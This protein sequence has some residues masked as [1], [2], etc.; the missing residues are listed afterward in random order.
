MIQ[1]TPQN[2]RIG[3]SAAN[4]NEAIRAAGQV[5]V[6]SG[7]IEPGYIESMI[8]REGQANTYLGNGISIPHGMAKDRELI[9]ATGISVVQLPEGV[10]WGPGKVAH[11]IV[12]IAAKSDEHLGV[13]A[14]LT[15]V[16][17]DPAKAELLAKTK[18]A[19]DIIAGLS[20]EAAEAAGE[21]SEGVAPP[22]G[23]HHVDAKIVGSAG[24]HARPATM[25][26][27]IASQ[28]ESDIRVQ[29]GI[30]IANGKSMAAILKLGTPCGEAIRI[31][32]V[33]PDAEAALKALKEAVDS[34]LG[35]VEEV[36]EVI[37][38]ADKWVPVSGGH[39][40]TG[41]SASP[42]IAIGPLYQFQTT[43]LV[44]E[45]K[46]KDVASEELALK[47]AIATANEQISE[48]YETGSEAIWEG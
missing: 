26:V 6:E 4:K 44:V 12:G 2:I 1:L 36:K 18:D 19:N 33:G 46:P 14:A 5:L 39:A 47:Q 37:T 28:F 13:L 38:E 11:L 30:K 15:D 16:L 7:F 35:D 17:D 27:E 22:P 41:V 40:L 45:D 32:A 10:E 31:I 8:G 21:P 20:R 29:Y 42:G 34:G 25:F 24:M 43:H 23:S 48:I 3:A 9:R